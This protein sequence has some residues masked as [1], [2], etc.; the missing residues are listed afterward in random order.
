MLCR[1]TPSDLRC[2]T[3]QLEASCTIVELTSSGSPARAPPCPAAP[4]LLDSLLSHIADQIAEYV[5]YQID[6]GAD[7][8]MMFD[9]WGGQLP[10]KEWDRW[11]RPY[12]ERIVRQVGGVGWG[13][14]AA[15]GSA[16]WP[17]SSSLCSKREGAEE[18]TPSGVVTACLHE[19]LC[20]PCSMHGQ[21]CAL[22]LLAAANP[23]PPPSHSSRSRPRTPTPP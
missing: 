9:S 21:G 11:S 8:V 1:T 5:K 23:C 14:R 17:A 2:V 15:W 16:S 6:S 3:Q 12:I 13:E 19:P 18:A 4:Q 7:C 20:A 10:P 22:V